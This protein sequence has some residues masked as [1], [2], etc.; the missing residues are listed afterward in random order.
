M[1]LYQWRFIDH[2]W[3]PIFGEGTQHVLDSDLSHEMGKWFRIPDS[4]V[5]AIAYL[6][7]VIFALLGSTSRW[8]D[9]PWLVIL[10]GIDVIP[11][12]AVS[13]ILIFM[14]GTVVG[15]WCFAC[16]ITACFSIILIC[17]AYREVLSSILYLHAVWKKSHSLGLVWNT[18]LGK[19]SAIAKEAAREIERGSG[20]R[21]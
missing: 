11:L 19:Y 18:L 10:F 17:L 4:I 6:S 7:D 3:D 2:V 16:L 1:G 20:R 8:R 13:A 15:A 5:G 9:K 12:G 14:Q 21:K